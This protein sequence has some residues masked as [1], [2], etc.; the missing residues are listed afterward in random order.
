MTDLPNGKVTFLFTDI[1]GSTRLA[2]R[3]QIKMPGALLIHHKILDEAVEFHKGHVFKIAGDAFCCSFENADDAVDASVRIQKKLAAEQWD[4][5]EIKVRIGI[6]TGDAEWKG[7]DY[8]GYITL[9]AT[10]RIMSVAYGRQILISESVFDLLKD[11]RPGISFRD[12]GSRRLKDLD[13]P[14]KLFQI[15]SSELVSDF[16]PLKTLDARPN[17]LPSQLTSFVGRE[18]E[19]SDVKKLLS[20][21]KLLTLLGPGGTGK[22]RLSLQT[23]ADVIDDFANGVWFAELDSLTNERLLPQTI[24]LALG[25][26]E[27]PRQDPEETISDYLRE[28]QLLL[29]LD[30]CEHLIDACSRL[31]QKLLSNSSELK[32]IATS[33]EALRVS[34]E[35]IFQVPS[36]SCPDPD[37]INSPEQLKEFE[38]VRLFLERALF[39][40]PNF[41]I[42]SDNASAISHICFQ[43]EGIPLAIE[44]AAAR[45]KVLSPEKINERLKDRF[46]LLIGGSRSSLPRQQTLRALVDWS[47]D[48]LIESEK[49]LLKRLSVFSGGWTLEAVENICSDDILK[50]ENIFDLLTALMEKSLLTFEAISERYRMLET[51]RQYGRDKMSS[52]EL[53]QLR[54][55]HLKFF[56]ALG[57]VSEIKITEPDQNKWLEKLE[58][59]LPNFNEALT[60]SVNEDDKEYGLRLAGSLGNFWIKHGH[61]TLGRL[62]YTKF[63]EDEINISSSYLVKVLN[64]AAKFARLQGDLKYA[65]TLLEESLELLTTQ[66]DK[67]GEAVTLRELGTIEMNKGEYEKAQKYYEDSLSIYTELKDEAGISSC[68]NNLGNKFHFQGDINTAINFYE[69]SLKLKRKIGDKSAISNSLTNLGIILSQ[70][71]D[72]KQAI[73]VLEESLHL[74][75]EQGNKSL[76]L[77]C[78]LNL[79]N[80][81][82]FEGQLVKSRSLTEE[83]LLLSNELGEKA[84]TAQAILRLGQL[85][86]MECNDE[87]AIRLFEESLLINRELGDKH[88]TAVC[89][90][91]LGN[92][93][94]KK[95]NYGEAVR[96]FKESMEIFRSVGNRKNVLV[97]LLNLGLFAIREKDYRSAKELYSESLTIF[98]N[99]GDKNI[100][101]P[102][103]LELIGELKKETLTAELTGL[104]SSIENCVQNMNSENKL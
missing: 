79:S 92:F 94:K 33:R 57:E 100:L 15:V 19:L 65:K 32:I 104:I 66:D 56:T 3:F 20:G 81:M 7:N 70:N 34:G 6:H 8:T 52:T 67:P 30:N 80:V 41:K 71:G 64:N 28:K 90:H 54:S 62:W 44:L 63:L 84:R 37:E 60:F 35:Q 9:A 13:D 93:F 86:E 102:E 98:Q 2:Q 82:R 48:L 40:D 23:G 76:I 26:T 73:S 25:V 69:E 12:L 43:L 27:V 11:M 78:L 22:T 45:V 53:A 24:A 31:A 99:E 39:A 29:I 47:Y 51:I 46:R 10:Q 88:D 87:N 89:L 16:P 72:N 103:I 42:D 21:T 18:K 83:A 36:L 5:L 91:L 68:L 59:D 49:I 1:E 14:L 101:T 85:S 17:N 74:Y 75:R 50:K 95:G 55:K 97:G 58:Q 4:E 61:I 77:A 96:Y 38:S